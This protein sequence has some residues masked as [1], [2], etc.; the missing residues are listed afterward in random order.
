MGKCETS[1]TSIGIKIVLSDLIKQIDE[2]TF[3][4]IK[5]M[6]E[7]G[8]IEDDNDFFNEVY[9][10]IMYDDRVPENYV[11]LKEYLINE[12]TNR[13][14]YHKSR[15]GQV[16]PTVDNGCL[17]DK[18]LLVPVKEI[19]QT[20]RWGHERY[21]TNGISIPVNFD[22]SINIEKYKGLEKTQ[23]VFILKQHSG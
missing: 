21:G 15:S 22:L 17:L 13:G 12:F 11:E 19:L 10:K 2:N 14:S 16:I 20:E 4:L 1:S 5:E 9:T 6:L 23:V 3:Y 7:E 8:F 18:H